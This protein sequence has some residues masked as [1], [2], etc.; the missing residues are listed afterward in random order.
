MPTTWLGE[1]LAIKRN[2]HGAWGMMYTESC[3]HIWTENIIIRILWKL[4]L[5][6]DEWDKWSSTHLCHINYQYL[7][8]NTV[9]NWK[10]EADILNKLPITQYGSYK[11]NCGSL[12]NGI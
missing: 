9:L 12:L 6:I 4:K 8:F 7:N 11:V 1:P 10:S 5:H 3:S 2:L